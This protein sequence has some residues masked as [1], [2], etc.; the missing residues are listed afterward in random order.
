ML[1]FWAKHELKWATEFFRTK[2][3]QNNNTHTHSHREASTGE[4][5]L[6]EIPTSFSRSFYLFI[7]DGYN[8]SN[9]LEWKRNEQH[10]V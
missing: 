2:N 5:G 7:A 1:A 8:S 4:R 9:H 10:S 3:P 6:W